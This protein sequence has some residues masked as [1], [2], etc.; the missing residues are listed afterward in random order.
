MNIFKTTKIKLSLLF[1]L[2]STLIYSQETEWSY[3]GDTNDGEGIYLKLEQDNSYSKKAWVKFVKPIT[4]KKNK[5]GKTIKVGGGY[6][7]GL[8]TVDCTDKVYSINSRLT[9]NSKGAVI[10]EGESYNDP[11]RENIIPDT[12]GE[13]IFKNICTE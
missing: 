12:V 6:T 8:W 5:Q 2:F 4:S 1:L 9:Y 10:S 7:I 3:L 11:E 13:F